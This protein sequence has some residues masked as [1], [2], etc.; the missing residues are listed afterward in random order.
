[1]TIVPES[2]CVLT[3]APMKSLQVV[4]PELC[5]IQTSQTC[6]PDSKSSAETSCGFAISVSKMIC[7]ATACQQGDEICLL[8]H[9]QGHMSGGR[10]ITALYV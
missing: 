1:M 9:S 3:E 2:T 4:E 10:Q 7:P 5:E 8:Q 6:I